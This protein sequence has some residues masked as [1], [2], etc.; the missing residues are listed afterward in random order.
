MSHLTASDTFEISIQPNGTQRLS[1]NFWIIWSDKHIWYFFSLKIRP[2]EVQKLKRLSNCTDQFCETCYKYGFESNPQITTELETKL[3]CKKVFQI[4]HV[5]FILSNNKNIIENIQCCIPEL[6]RRYMQNEVKEHGDFQ[7][8]L[9]KAYYEEDEA[10]LNFS[11]LTSLCCISAQKL[12]FDFLKVHFN[13][14]R[15]HV[16]ICSGFIRNSWYVSFVWQ[17]L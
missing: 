4:R 3:R 2:E 15:R 13:T 7:T 9:K 12:I 5:S 14:W 10:R 17:F 11:L 6:I 16:S 1:S 8:V